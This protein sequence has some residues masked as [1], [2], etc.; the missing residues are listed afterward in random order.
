VRGYFYGSGPD[1]ARLAEMLGIARAVRVQRAGSDLEARLD[2][3]ETI[4]A[5]R[6]P[7]NRAIKKRWRGWYLEIRWNEPFPRF[8]LV[9]ATRHVGSQYFGPFFGRRLPDEIRRLTE[10]LFRL[11]SCRDPVRPDPGGSACLQYELGLCSAPC[12]KAVGLNEY[13]AQ[14][15]SAARLLSDA[16]YAWELHRK[17]EQS[18]DEASRRLA[19]ERAAETQAR[20]EWLQQLEDYRFALES[21]GGLRSW[22]IV[23]PGPAEEERVLLPVAQGRV[24][25]RKRVSWQVDEW[26]PAVEDACYAVRVGQLRASSVFPPEEM[27]PSMLVTRWLENGAPDGLVFDLTRQGSVDVISRLRRSPAEA[28]AGPRS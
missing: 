24:L 28:L 2:E 9:R 4:L 5:S 14:M 7:Y 19:F 11:R 8:Q 10:K 3:A 20:L 18:R 1:D 26:I 6:P 23:L 12:I 16:G 21:D 27:V 22:L 25:P 17:L 15:R 13:R